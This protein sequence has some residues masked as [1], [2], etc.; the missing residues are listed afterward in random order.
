MDE[1][2]GSNGAIELPD[3]FSAVFGLL[4]VLIGT[5]IGVLSAQRLEQKRS[6]YSITMA[7]LQEFHSSEMV[8]H[9]DRAYLALAAKPYVS[10]EAAYNRSEMKDRTSLS[11]VFHFLERIYVLKECGLIQEDILGKVMGRYFQFWHSNVLKH[12]LPE[13]PGSEWED[14]LH[15]VRM[16]VS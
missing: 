11:I 1:I 7:L 8:Y 3:L 15:K 12:L 5:W 2:F 16:L 14:L 4:G 10:F 9:R 13:P 6:K